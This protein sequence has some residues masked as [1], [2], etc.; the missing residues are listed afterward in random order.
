MK[1]L[2]TFLLWGGLFSAC[3]TN[4]SVTKLNTMAAKQTGNLALEMG[5][6]AKSRNESYD[7]LAKSMVE[8]QETLLDQE[9]K[10]FYSEQAGK[11]AG[12][13]ALE[14]Q[15]QAIAASSNEEIKLRKSHKAEL[16]SM[17]KSFQEGQK[18][19]KAPKE[20]LMET[21]KALADLAK[22]LPPEEWARF[23]LEY[24]SETNAA[25]EKLRKEREEAAKKK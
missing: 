13:D 18:E 25:A 11:L 21:S 8:Q 4:Q 9:E 7:A 10:L 19:L 24:G 23:Y 3:S 12:D 2:L 17:Q 20:A 22:E 14:K 5:S 6:Y 15:F 16:E 1:R